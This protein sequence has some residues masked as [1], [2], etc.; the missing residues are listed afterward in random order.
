MV[1][2]WGLCTGDRLGVKRDETL[3]A[4]WM[5]LQP[6][7]SHLVLTQPLSWGWGFPQLQPGTVELSQHLT[8]LGKPGATG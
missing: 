7:R 8:L 3:V 4:I 2:L 1:R 6:N 5:Q